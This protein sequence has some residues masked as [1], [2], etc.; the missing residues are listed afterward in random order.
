MDPVFGPLFLGRL[1]ATSGVWI[2]NI[3]SAILAFE[4]SGSALTVG[5]V[6]AAQ[7]GPQ[8]LFAPLSGAIA[9]RGNRKGQLVLGRMIVALGSG[10]LALAV[11]IRGVDGL[12]GAWVVVAAAGVV[13]TGFAIGVPA[14]N[15]L[16]PSLVRAAELPTAIALDSLPLSLARAVG[17]AIGVLVAT[18]AG[19]AAALGVGAGANLAFALTIVFLPMRSWKPAGGKDRSVRAGVKFVRGHPAIVRLLVAVTGIGIGADPVITLSPSLAAEFGA[20]ARFVGVL[21]SA[22]GLGA[23]VAIFSLTFVRRRVGL[24]R[25]GIGGLT[26]LS[27]GLAGAGLSPIRALAALALVIGGA[28]MTMAIAS[29][30]TQLQELLPEEFRGRVMGLY[31]VSFLGSR[32]IAA[33][34]NGFVSDATSPSFAFILAGLI[35][36]A[37]AMW[38][39]ASHE[40]ARS[41]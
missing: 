4:L 11:W 22:F 25:A 21:A 38:A 35:V 5:A 36:L 32:P 12:P 1:V 29:L 34:M 10:S 9:D 41:P 30:S 37:I 33:A 39:R 20:D 2:S 13:G 27:L 40:A 24:A 3:V 18:T 8:L 17:P 31:A 15:A 7:F 19:P 26:L 6:S 14:M 16:L 28:G 23:V